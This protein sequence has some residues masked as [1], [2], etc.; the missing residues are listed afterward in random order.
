MVRCLREKFVDR[1]LKSFF[2]WLGCKIGESPGYF[3]VVPLLL[4][5]LCMSGFQQMDYEFEPEYLFSP[6]HG[7]AKSERAVQE[8]HFPTNYSSFKSSRISR[9]GKF[10]RIIVTAKDTGSMLRTELWDQLL[11]LDQVVYNAT[12]EFDVGGE[13]SAGVVPLT[14][15]DLCATYNGYC[16]ENE[17]LL[18]ATI[19]PAIENR[20]ISLTYPIFFDPNTFKSYT[21]PFFFGD[22]TLSDVNTV[23]SVGAV[24]IAYFL[25]SS[26]SERNELGD[27]WE[28]RVLDS[29]L[30]LKA[31][32]APDLEVGVFVSNTPAWEMERSRLSI[33]EI[34]C[35][36]IILMVA[37]SFVAS[38]MA[39]WAKSKPLIGFGGLFSA[40]LATM[41]GF[42]FCCYAGVE[43][44]S[45]NMASP[46]LLLGI[47]IDDTFVLL[48]S[49]RR[50]SVHATVPE[51]M[52]R[53]YADAAVSITVTSATNFLSFMVGAITPFP[54]VR[55]FCLYTGISV[56]FIYV[57]HCTLFGAMLAYSGYAEAKNKHGLFPCVTATPRSLAKDRGFLYR[58]FLVGGINPDDPQNPEDN[59]EHAGMVFFRDRVGPVLNKTWVKVLVLTFFCAYIGGAC[60]GVTNIR[61]GLEKRNTANYDSYSVEFY[62][63]DDKYF[64]EY[65]Y[66]INVM[67]TG[68]HL[69]LSDTATRD[70]ILGI[71]SELESTPFIDGNV[72]S[73]WLRDFLGYVRRAEEFGGDIIP[74]NTEQEISAAVRDYLADPGSEQLLDIEFKEDDSGN[75]RI[76]AIRFIIQGHNIITSQMEQDMVAKLRDICD[77]HSTPDDIAITVF[78][79]WFIYIDQ[80]LAILPQTI[81]CIIVTAAVMVVIAL[82]L[83]PSPI[84]SFWVSFSIVSIEVGVIGYMTWWGVRLDGVALINLIM[85]IGFSVD[86]SAHIC[87]HYITEDD[88]DPNDRIRGSLYALGVPIL[89]GAGSTITGVL[90]LAFAPS[91]LFVTFFKM[92]FLVILLGALHGLV[93]LP[94]LLSLFGT[95]SCS[96]NRSKSSSKSTRSSGISTPTTISCGNMNQSSSCYAVNLGFI[97][98]SSS[99]FGRTIQRDT[100]AGYGDAVPS[101]PRHHESRHN[102]TIWTQDATEAARSDLAMMDRSDI[103]GTGSRRKQQASSQQIVETSATSSSS[104]PSGPVVSAATSSRRRIV[105]GPKMMTAIESVNTA[106]EETSAASSSSSTSTTPRMQMPE[107]KVDERM[108]RYKMNY[109]ESGHGSKCKG[110]DQ[111]RR[112]SGGNSHRSSSSHHHHRSNYHGDSVA[113]CSKKRVISRSKSQI[114]YSPS[115]DADIQFVPN[116]DSWRPPSP[117]QAP[118]LPQP[119][120][121]VDQPPTSGKHPLR[122]Y[123]SVPYH[124]FINDDSCSSDESFNDRTRRRHHQLLLLQQ[125]QKHRQLQDH[126]NHQL[127]KNGY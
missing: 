73:C 126:F 8:R 84:C 92:I 18:L 108:K 53:S 67:F 71:I 16:Y 27:R 90:G 10:A 68:P 20:N 65:S 85:C 25:D 29:L 2:Y 113:N 21:L 6:T 30:D 118:T 57:W 62:D 107:K 37:F 17:I 34:L 95:G 9:P 122:K 64:K 22:V 76:N 96:S 63:M 114:A 35:L 36:N 110:K 104:S 26:D 99:D 102:F 44:I 14:Y 23:E 50:S 70:K 116:G 7:V 59:R 121:L 78:H 88:K 103:K 91:Y 39:D 120:M 123:H 38:L 40:A 61:E 109:G 60:W 106:T 58:L 69:D 98:T 127:H 33:T 97:P 117:P 125:E 93:L 56:A 105:K 28:K 87:Y 51:R 41:S 82:I 80:Y 83:I 77:R 13:G 24:G 43:F 94:V 89:Q 5:A 1:T 79:P 15:S 19:M 101:G 119:E 86:F 54:C 74:I 11:Y 124:S 42:G 46:F 55:I 72:T 112:E 115:N 66:P 47:G 75:T 12:V 48:S 32:Y 100:F 3:L 111:R 81:Q 49:W 31:V 4:T 45:L 52:G